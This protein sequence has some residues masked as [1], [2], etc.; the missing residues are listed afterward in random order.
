MKLSDFFKKKTMTEDQALTLIRAMNKK[1]IKEVETKINKY[2]ED[3]NAYFNGHQTKLEVKLI[4]L[5][6]KIRIGGGEY[7]P[8]QPIFKKIKTDYN[9]SF[10]QLM[11]LTGIP[12]I[13]SVDHLLEFNLPEDASKTTVQLSG[14]TRALMEISKREVWVE[15]KKR[16]DLLY[17]LHSNASKLKGGV[18]RPF[19]AKVS[20]EIRFDLKT[21][22]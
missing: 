2:Y 4:L 1:I 12:F 18:G 17:K 7:R 15:A 6:N 13:I 22:R 14:L 5:S 8:D 19:I 3:V 9:R 11:E 20:F 21:L 10:E 16:E